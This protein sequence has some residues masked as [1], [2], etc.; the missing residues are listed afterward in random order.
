MK[1][2]QLT[3]KKPKP[4][5]C[6]HCG[7]L[8]T[9]SIPYCSPACAYAKTKDKGNHSVNMD[10]YKTE[11]PKKYKLDPLKTAKIAAVT[12][13]HAYIRARDFGKPCIC[14][15]KP[16]GDDYHA[17]H[18]WESGNFSAVRF[19]EDN[20]H[21]QRLDC[22]T[23]KGGDSGSYRENLITKIGLFDVVCLDMTRSKKT[24]RTIE[25]YKDISKHYKQK[26]KQLERG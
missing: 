24:K 11:K 16:L 10:N 23:F 14:C 15:G 8:T 4:R 20:I 3:P 17:G 7:E 18:F 19:N 9:N 26:L 21:G 5:P 2:S 12:D 22:N 13:C 6:K 25:D 1:R